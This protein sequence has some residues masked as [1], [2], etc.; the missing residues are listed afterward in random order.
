[1]VDGGKQF[2]KDNDEQ[3]QGEFLIRTK[4]ALRP[5]SRRSQ[6]ALVEA[7]GVVCSKH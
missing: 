2:F 5:G 6:C 4:L 1:L 7:Q 3:L